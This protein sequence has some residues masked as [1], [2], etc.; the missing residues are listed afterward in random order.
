MFF[1]KSSASENPCKQLYPGQ[2]ALQKVLIVVA[3][4]CI[5]VMLLT[6]PLILYFRHKRK[7]QVN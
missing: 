7:S 1:L 3:V 4:L 5:P 6:K 2:E